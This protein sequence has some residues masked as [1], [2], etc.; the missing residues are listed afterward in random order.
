[1][2]T[3]YTERK[4]VDLDAF[5]LKAIKV[6]LFVNLVISLLTMVREF[7]M[8]S[9]S[10]P[11]II[12]RVKLGISDP[13]TAYKYKV[14][15]VND[16]MFGGKIMTIFLLVSSF[17]PALTIPV[18][19]VYFKKLGLGY[20]LL[21][22]VNILL[23]IMHYVGIGTNIG[24]FTVCLTVIIVLAAT[25]LA[26]I[27]RHKVNQNKLMIIVAILLVLLIVF[28]LFFNATIGSRLDGD[29]WK[30]YAVGGVYPTEDCKLFDFIPESLQKPVAM[31]TMYTTQGYYAMSMALDLPWYPMFLTGGSSFIQSYADSAVNI[32]QFSYSERLAPY[33]WHPTVNWH[34]LYLWIANDLSF[35]G[36]IIYMLI[37][38]YFFAYFFRVALRDKNCLAIAIFVSLS[39]MAFFIPANNQI[40]GF[41]ISFVKFAFLVLFYAIFV[42]TDAKQH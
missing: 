40:F 1:M 27:Y 18:G 7:S 3:S 31:I 35:F 42:K 4:T 2:K 17:V 9:I 19:C 20:K 41:L 22:G 11:G 16:G 5:M 25:Y 13:N 29:A 8:S 10:I 34:S 28:L 12:D 37:F 6:L 36:V 23:E 14:S 32:S 26:K 38:G 15:T 39:I 30:D 24:I 33:G 21:L